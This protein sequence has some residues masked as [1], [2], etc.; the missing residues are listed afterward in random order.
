MDYP[1]A[2]YGHCV[3][4]INETHVFSAGGKD[5]SFRGA[6]YIYSKQTGFVEQESMKIAR[7]DHACALFED[8]IYAVAGY[9][10]VDNVDSVE[11]FSLSSLTWESSVSVAPTLPVSTF[12]GELMVLGGSLT[13][14]GG[15]GNKMIF[16]MVKVVSGSYTHYDWQ[17]VGEW[18]KSRYYFKMLKWN[19]TDCTNW[20]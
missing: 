16:K 10:F 6:A 8:K 13:Y 9:T 7:Y 1:I 15:S 4:K 14:F 3:V 12:G 17:E 20:G 18:D 5:G 19:A 11:F 2:V